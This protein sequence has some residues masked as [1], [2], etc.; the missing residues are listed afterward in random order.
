[1]PK[2][3][4]RMSER[5]LL[6]PAALADRL[7]ERAD[8]RRDARP[9]GT[10]TVHQ[11]AHARLADAHSR[12][13]LG[14]REALQV[15]Q[16]R[17]LALAICEARAEPLEQLAQPDA[18]IELSREVELEGARVE[19]LGEARAGLGAAPA[20][21]VLLDR[22]PEAREHQPPGRVRDLLPIE[23]RHVEALPR[24]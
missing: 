24:L 11:L 15:A 7:H 6:A 2:A 14:A 20:R 19:L 23:D 8:L 10:A 12:G 4:A 9:A 13:G 22:A 21:A 17:G 1:M 3:S 5:L 18:V 16:H